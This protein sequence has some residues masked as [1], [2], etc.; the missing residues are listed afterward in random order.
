MDFR[1][2]IIMQQLMQENI[3]HKFFQILSAMARLDNFTMR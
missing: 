3:F 1:G 2:K